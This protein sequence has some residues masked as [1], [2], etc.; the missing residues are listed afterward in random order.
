MSNQSSLDRFEVTETFFVVSVSNMDR[1]A[2]FYT[3]ALGASIAWASPRWSSLHIAG[4]RVGLFANP[5]HSGAHVG[6][7]FAVSDLEAACASVARAQGKV[8]TPRMQAAPNVFVA[9]VADTEGNI[10]ALRQA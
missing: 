1:A 3:A 8:I 6:L 2:A 5:E 10:F 9:E 4:V 7:N